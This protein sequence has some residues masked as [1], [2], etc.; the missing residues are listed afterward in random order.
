MLTTS[1]GHCYLMMDELQQAYSA[2]QSALY[3][4]KDPNVCL[5]MLQMSLTVLTRI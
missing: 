1:A 2:Y 5:S 4:L 3:N